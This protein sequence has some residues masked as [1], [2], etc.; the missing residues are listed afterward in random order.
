MEYNVWS[1]SIQGIKNLDLSREI[2]FRDDRKNL[3]R[4]RHTLK[5]GKKFG[6]IQF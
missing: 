4:R 6:T 3:N 1:E 2:R 5:T